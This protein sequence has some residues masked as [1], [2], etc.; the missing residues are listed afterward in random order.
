MYSTVRRNQYDF[1]LSGP[2]QVKLHT[3]IEPIDPTQ[4]HKIT[5]RIGVGLQADDENIKMHMESLSS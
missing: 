2:K 1:G 4:I 3:I 5:F